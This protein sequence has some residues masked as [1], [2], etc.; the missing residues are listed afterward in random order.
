M[1]KIALVKDSYQK[2]APKRKELVHQ[3]YVRLFNLSP[4]IKQL[5]EDTTMD[6][7]ESMFQSMLDH[8]VSSL[9]NFTFM[10]Q[11]LAALGERHVIYGAKKRHY[12]VAEQ[13]LLETLAEF[14]GNEFTAEVRAAWRTV[15]RTLVKLMINFELGDLEN[16]R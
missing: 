4:E 15:Y 9:E 13:A 5:F 3:F 1:D 14:L 6:V 7:Q 11:E 8:A 10:A 2:I 12:V 16:P